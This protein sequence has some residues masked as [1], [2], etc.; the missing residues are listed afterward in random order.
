MLGP[1][2][3]GKG[4][5]SERLAHHLK[6]AHLSTGEMLRQ[7][8]D[9]ESSVGLEAKKF[10]DQGQLV[11]D[12]VIIELVGQRLDQTDCASGYL[13]D[14][15]PRTLSQAEALDN[16]LSRRSTPL[17]GVIE[18]EVNEDVLV[19]RMLARGR[20]DDKPEVIRQR[21][22]THHEQT[23]PLS[24]YYRQRNVLETIDALGSVDEVFGRLLAA[25]QKLKSRPR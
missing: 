23:E 3:A 24:D 5:Q 17:S 21:M 22:A 15:F 9:V 6:V 20:G 10:I 4:T 14:G 18:L 25:V 2:G 1:P 11:P 13:L 8:I 19:D 12:Q 16:Y 7:A